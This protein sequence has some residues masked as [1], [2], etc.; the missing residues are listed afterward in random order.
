MNLTLNVSHFNTFL[1]FGTESLDKPAIG[2]IAYFSLMFCVFIF[3]IIYVIFIKICR[4]KFQTM[5]NSRPSSQISN[6][7]M[8]EQDYRQ[9][10][11]N[12]RSSAPVP[13]RD[14][15]YS[16]T[17]RP[18]SYTGVVNKTIEFSSVIDHLPPSYSEI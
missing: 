13:I 14:S 7:P 5:E 1:M 16:I 3:T 2:L 9:P 12:T 15:I 4:R 18:P 6:L 8:P 11:S 17:S 10:N